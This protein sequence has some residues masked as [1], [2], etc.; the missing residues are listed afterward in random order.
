M[1]STWRVVKDI[2]CKRNRT[3]SPHKIVNDDKEIADPGEIANVFNNYFAN[4]GLNQARKI[5]SNGTNYKEYL[6]NPSQAS[7]FFKP[8]DSFEILDIVFSL[9]NSNSCGHDEISTSFLKQVIGLILVPLAHICNLSLVTGVFPSSLK[10]A[11]VVPVHKKDNVM[12]VCNYRPIS[13]LSSFS[14]LLERVVYN[15]LYA[16]LY[17]F[18]AWQTGE[19]T[20]RKVR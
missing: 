16:F 11:K 12:N 14:K 3:E 1:S 8:V 10:L 20:D 4:I 5:D 19:N 6:V 13:I 7:L 15:R 17:P 2:L 18:Q 9:K